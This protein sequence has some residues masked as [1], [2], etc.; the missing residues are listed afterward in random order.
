MRRARLALAYD[1]V[2][3]SADLAPHLV[4]FSYT[5][6][7]HG[8]QD[9]ISVILED[10]GGLWRGP[11]F[12]DRGATLRASL[13]VADWLRPGASGV[14]NCGTFSVDEIEYSWPPATVRIGAVAVS[15]DSDLRGELKSRAWEASTL[16]DIAGE[17]ASGA[18]LALLFDSRRNPKWS[19]ID[20][21]EESDAALV[22]RLCR[23]AALNCKVTAGKLVIFAGEDYDARPAALTITPDTAGLLGGTLRAQTAQ[24]YRGAS[25]SYW[26]AKAQQLR[27]YSYTPKRA[28][29]SGKT[30]KLNERYETKAQAEV[31]AKA[32]LR[33]ANGQE[34]AGSLTMLG[35]PDVAAGQN[36]ALS[37]F[38]A[39]D[40]KYAVEEA[41][42]S[43][44]NGGGYTT[45][46]ALRVTVGQVDEG[47]E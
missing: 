9:D 3:I 31:A 42:H 40:G 1:G 29:R 16:R 13:V 25:A 33:T 43:Y 10:R 41:R 17:I 34:F 36:V 28:P 37:G 8:K 18:G 38:G 19:R 22:E 26:D 46:L 7:A 27:A 45:A 47:G 14:L 2:D 32:A 30:L 5:D 11:W 4:G 35:R 21:R 12:P 23:E 20:Q 15:I 6:R 39:Y 44:D 24:V